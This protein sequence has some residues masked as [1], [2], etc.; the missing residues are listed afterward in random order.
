[1]LLCLKN[2]Y[3]VAWDNR[4]QNESLDIHIFLNF[5]ALKC[6]G[7]IL[8]HLNCVLMKWIF[9]PNQ[10]ENNYHTTSHWIG[11]P[12]LGTVSCQNSLFLLIIITD[13]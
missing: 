7:Q 5:A 10:K 4:R 12:I 1:M 3:L 2:C 9:N 6:S 13:W 8:N 11:L